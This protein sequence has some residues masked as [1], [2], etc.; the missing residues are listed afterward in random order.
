MAS[1]AS[2]IQQKAQVMAMQSLRDKYKSE[3]SE[4]YRQSVILLGG[5][6]RASKEERIA[7]LQ[8]EIAKLQEGK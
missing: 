8:A 5:T 3:Y 1:V 4:M 6:P 2:K 7:K